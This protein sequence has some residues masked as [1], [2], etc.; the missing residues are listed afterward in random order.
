MNN[1]LKGIKVVDL[2][3][4]LA[5]PSVGMFL[6]ELGADVL[7]IENPNTNGDITR[8]WKSPTE[9]KN[10]SLS[11]YYLSVNSFKK[12]EFLNFNE[13]QSIQKIHQLVL[14]SDIVLCNFKSGDDK[15][16]QLDYDTLKSISPSIIYGHITGF[17]RNNSRV[18][19][20]LIL[21]AETGFMYLNREPE[22]LPNKMPVA[23]I[24]VLAA[25]HLKEGIL[26]ALYQRVKTGKG[27]YV[28]CSLYD[29]AVCSLINQAT[30]YLI[31][32]YN[33]PPMGSKHPNIAPYGEIFE[34]KNHQ[35]IT[36]AIGTDKQFQ[37]LCEILNLPDLPYLSD[38][39]NNKER[40]NNREKLYRILQERIKNF[41]SDDLYEKCLQS[42][43]PVAIIKD[44][45]QVMKSPQT[46][47]NIRPVNIDGKTYNIITSIAFEII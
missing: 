18:A 6:A 1:I 26:L 41:T 27:A 40:V 30:N 4:V 39:A 13:P 47:K 20:D 43:V 33:P 8:Q 38:F 11:A 25:H 46:Q 9:D 7:K 17:G 15:K 2:S 21:Q 45:E 32:N 22:H 34:T 19:F 3:S 10:S 29:A 28:H 44:I 31:A 35:L 5:G 12:I 24:D 36:F 23:L 37:T 42:N 14:E 16:F